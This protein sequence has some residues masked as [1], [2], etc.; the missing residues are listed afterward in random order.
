VRQSPTAPPIEDRPLRIGEVAT[1]AGVSTRT[2]RYYQELGLLHPSGHTPG[3]AR[4]YGAADVERLTRILELRD[5]L[6]FNLDEIAEILTVEDHLSGL[7]AEWVSGKGLSARRRE[8]ILAEATEL[9]HRLQD[10]VRAKLARLTEFLGEL[11]AKVVRYDELALELR[12]GAAGKTR[13][14]RA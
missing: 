9:N 1:A 13:G 11:E 5:L 8:E 3:L 2:L 12:A 6:G 7:R 4:R 10:Q 14:Q